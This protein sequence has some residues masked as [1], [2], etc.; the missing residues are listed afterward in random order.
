MI[1]IPRSSD[2]LLTWIGRASTTFRWEMV[3]SKQGCLLL[4]FPFLALGVGYLGIAFGRK[5]MK[6]LGLHASL[7]Q[8]GDS[9]FEVHVRQLPAGARAVKQLTYAVTQSFLHVVLR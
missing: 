3:V 4:G 6:G 1:A 7:A 9:F 5:S 2:I 8:D